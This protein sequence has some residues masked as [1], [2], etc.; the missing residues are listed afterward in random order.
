M[1][2]MSAKLAKASFEWS[3]GERV[4]KYIAERINEFLQ[5]VELDISSNG[6]IRG[7]FTDVKFKPK[8]LF[9]HLVPSLN[10]ACWCR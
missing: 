6:P 1:M 3:H 9:C 2:S 5:N 4:E 10:Q 8:V 7:T